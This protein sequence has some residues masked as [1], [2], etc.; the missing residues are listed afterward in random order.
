MRYLTFRDRL[1]LELEKYS[2]AHPLGRGE[3]SPQTVAL[4]IA[5]SVSF[6]TPS[7]LDHQ[8][9][10]LI[11]VV[12]LFSG[13]GGTSYGFRAIGD[14]VR[15]YR[16]IAAADLDKHANATYSKN[17]GVEPFCLDLR[18]VAASTRSIRRFGEELPRSKGA[19]L[20]LIGCAPCQGFSSHRKKH[21]DKPVDERNSLVGAFA[22]I[23]SVLQPELVVMENVPELLSSKY[24]RFYEILMRTLEKSG[25]QVRAQVVSSAG[26][27]VPQERFRAIVIAM[28]RPFGML[29]PYLSEYC[30]R[31]VG[32]AI[33]LLPPL[34]PGVPDPK[35]A[36]HVTTNHRPST[37]ATIKK[38][39]KNGGSRPFGAGPKCLD[40]VRG[41]YDVYGRL[42]WDKPAITITGYSR[43]PASGRYVHPQQDRGLSI[44]EAALLQGFPK[45]YSFEG[46]FDDK[47]MQ[48]GNAVP[49]AFSA[50]LAGYLL[51]ELVAD[52]EPVGMEEFPGNILAPVS[53]SFSS[54]IAGIK[55]KR[56]YRLVG[57]ND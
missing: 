54:V 6:R 34:R 21:W 46:P 9:Q 7:L 19:P 39:P 5:K 24:W 43:N 31:T 15:S 25:Y 20:V 35:D 26:F 36:M 57:A 49:P 42:F 47:F 44:R 18:K 12:D 8:S 55:S 38:V 1:R 2:S 22:R 41:F 51:G 37:I 52:R 32:D 10:G 33:G 23:A 4:R 3:S 14:A 53:N 40:R 45:N 27:G 16:V 48:I 13:C 17:I 28:K 50:Y 29:R 56:D 11:D 30:F